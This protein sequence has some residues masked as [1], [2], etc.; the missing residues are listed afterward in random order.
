VRT[1]AIVTSGV[2]VV[3]LVAGWRFHR[4]WRMAW[5]ADDADY[6]LVEARTHDTEDD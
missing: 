3:L 2:A 4:A 5:D 1:A 6:A